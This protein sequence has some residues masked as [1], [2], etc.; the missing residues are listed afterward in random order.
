MQI[1]IQLHVHSRTIPRYVNRGSVHT[2]VVRSSI[3]GFHKKLDLTGCSK[4]ELLAF[5]YKHDA[6]EF[7]EL[8]QKCQGKIHRFDREIDFCG[9][10]SAVIDN[11][12]V[13]NY[14]YSCTDSIKP[15]YMDTIIY[16]HM[17]RMC[18]MHNFDM[19]IVYNKR[20]EQ[21]KEECYKVGMDCY[22]Y[23]TKETPHRDIQEKIL[24]DMLYYHSDD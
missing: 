19:L 7:M 6:N 15:I 8:M 14:A 5:A 13:D 22:E 16:N 10:T 2:L 11:S 18:L 20:I 21:L 1:H 9:S 24:R 3:F 17:E 12:S 23:I 4:T